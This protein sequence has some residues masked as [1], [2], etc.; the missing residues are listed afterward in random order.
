MPR[1][2]N[3]A[4]LLR[5]CTFLIE[6]KTISWASSGAR[7]EAFVLLG[8]LPQAAAS[9]HS[10]ARVL[11]QVMD[12]RRSPAGAEGASLR[13]RAR[14]G[15]VGFVIGREGGGCMANSP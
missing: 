13:R 12:F 14:A 11:H 6:Q 15:V 8:A 1:K 2:T 3:T 4:H 7:E 5:A 10:L 9:T